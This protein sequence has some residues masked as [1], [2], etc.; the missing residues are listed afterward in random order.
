MLLLQLIQSFILFV[1]AIKFLFFPRSFHLLFFSASHRLLFL[2]LYKPIELILVSDG[3]FKS[4]FVIADT[5]SSGCSLALLIRH[6]EG[7]AHEGDLQW[8]AAVIA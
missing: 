6:H 5:K 1:E 8:F 3:I 7:S 2:V 4:G